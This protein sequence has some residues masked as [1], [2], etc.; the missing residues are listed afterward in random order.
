MI[1][2]SA[3]SYLNT[4]P[5]I[6]GLNHGVFSKEINLSLDYP[7]KCADKF[8]NREVDV[9]L[10]PVVIMRELTYFNIISDYCIGSDG[11]VETVC[12]Y[13][14]VPIQQVENI[15]LD[16]QSRTSI[17]LLKL[18]LK[19]YWDLSPNLISSEVGFEDNI[20][21]KNAGL[22]IGDR[23]FFLN[24]KYNFVYD[25]SYFWK[26]MTGLPFV[27]A[28]WLSN[29]ELSDHFIS[30]FNNAMG[31]GLN[32]LDQ[33]L[34]RENY[35]YFNCNNPKDYLENKISYSLDERK[36]EAMRYFLDKL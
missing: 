26:K 23:A 25:L 17:E 35:N 27:F 32:N 13:S 9:A 31:F 15:Y 8:K 33:V 4:M 2:I 18:L 24:T 10:V 29:K 20:T 19:D 11:V 14:D 28:V 12:L 21:A 34:V 1:N 7:S 36:I 22:V 5:L 3:V 30:G 16:Y 6:Y